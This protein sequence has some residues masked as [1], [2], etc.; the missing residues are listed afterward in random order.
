MIT[1][2]ANFYNVLLQTPIC[3]D[4]SAYNC[5]HAQAFHYSTGLFDGFETEPHSNSSKKNEG[6]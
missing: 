1:C 4:G 3:Q 6:V 2:E 5:E